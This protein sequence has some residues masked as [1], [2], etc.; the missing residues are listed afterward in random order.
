M[1]RE[2]EMPAMGTKLSSATAWVVA[3][4]ALVAQR[5]N[6]NSDGVLRT[7]AGVAIEIEDPTAAVFYTSDYVTNVADRNGLRIIGGTMSAARLTS[8]AH[9]W[10][11]AM[12]LEDLKAHA[13]LGKTMPSIETIVDA[14][15]IEA[16]AAA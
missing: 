5:V 15:T 4:G 12:T 7:L 14:Y 16:E 1:A 6:I 11:S 9:A 2:Q 10:K 13:Y 3:P 8:V